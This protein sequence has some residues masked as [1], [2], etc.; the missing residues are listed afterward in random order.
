MHSVTDLS[1]N[2][3]YKVFDM[4][5][6]DKSG[7][8]DF[9]EFYLLICIL[10][11]I[12]VS[13]VHAMHQVFIVDGL[14]CMHDCVFTCTRSPHAWVDCRAPNFCGWPCTFELYIRGNDFR[15]SV[16]Q[17]L[18]AKQCT[19]QF[20]VAVC[21][22]QICSPVLMHILA[23]EKCGSSTVRIIYDIYINLYIDIQDI[24][25]TACMHALILLK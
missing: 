23:I 10:L 12:R 13:T 14:L 22:F 17:L 6:V 24:I 15:G 25:Y 5:D 20:F 18:P 1:K 8:L 11:A 3:I 21:K 2:Q 9:D 16:I 4:L 7:L 19:M